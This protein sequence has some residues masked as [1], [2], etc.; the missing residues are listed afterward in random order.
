M[1]TQKQL[2][3]RVRERMS[4]TGERYTAAR[5]QVAL[6]R[7]RLEEARRRLASAKEL[8]SDEKLTEATG[9]DWGAWLAILDR[10]GAGERKHRE[11]ADFLIAH[12]GV[13]GWW[14]QA[15]TTGYERARG[16][17][18]KHQQPNG[19]TV[20]VSK[21]V[22]VP[23][24]ALF[25]AFVDPQ[26]RRRWLTDGPMSPRTMQPNKVARFDWG[27]GS[28][29]VLVTFEAKG[30]SRATAYVAHERLPDAD[31]AEA[32]KAA[33]KGRLAALKTFLEATDA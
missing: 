31:V 19:F 33:W 26:L 6:G 29:R 7:E 14:A 1:T 18:L 10:C 9:A 25:D 21:T 11:T 2:K 20:Y 28:T 5:R 24:G 22:S 17:R 32:A 23:I 8:A 27:D 4:K 30:P 16:L 3:R 15:I 12:H 13:P